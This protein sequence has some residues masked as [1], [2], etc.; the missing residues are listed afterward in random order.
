MASSCSARI[1]SIDA[2]RRFFDLVSQKKTL[3]NEEANFTQ[4]EFDR[5]KA[6]ALLQ[7]DRIKEQDLFRARTREINAEDG[8]IEARARYQR[9]LDELKVFLGLPRSARFD[10]A[11]EEPPY[12]PVVINVESAIHAAR[13]NRLD[14]ITEKEQLEDSMRSLH[15]A[16]NS[17]LP[18]LTL[19]A[20]AGLAGGAERFRGASPDDWDASI[21]LTM[22]I[23]LQRRPERNSYRSAVISHE[24]AERAYELLLDQL[25]L[26]IHDQMRQLRTVEKRILPAERTDPTAGK[27]RGD[28]RDPLRGR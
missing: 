24:R 21:G 13:H 4:A 19:T 14:L 23:P 22:E 28:Q 8:L 17:L 5:R 9:A 10:V 25:D 15:I 27:G 2:A 12:D 1:F 20:G 7:V 3:V 16:E 11:D 26:D 18:D 6:E